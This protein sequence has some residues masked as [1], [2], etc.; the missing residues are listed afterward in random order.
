MKKGRASERGWENE[1]GRI[2]SHDSNSDADRN[3]TYHNARL[4]KNI[5]RRRKQAVGRD[6]QRGRTR[7]RR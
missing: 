2:P 6:P 5:V 4:I 7:K 3:W 1:E